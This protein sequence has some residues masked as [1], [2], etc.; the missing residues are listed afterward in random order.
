MAQREKGPIM[1][2]VELPDGRLYEADLAE[3]ARI[4]PDDFD[5]LNLAL[6]ETPAQYAYW[7]M[8]AAQA[9]AHADEVEARL[10]VHRATLYA[11][12]EGKTVD[13]RKGAVLLDKQVQDLLA[14]LRQARADA[15]VLGVAWKTIRSRKESLLAIASNIRAEMDNRLYVGRR[16]GA[17]LL[18]TPSGSELA[19]RARKGGK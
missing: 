2:R 3:E 15:A 14:Q 9:D 13:D 10:E 19:A 4:V 7:A 17:K 6:A 1:L 5:A 16:E 8:R 18:R 11:K 12:A